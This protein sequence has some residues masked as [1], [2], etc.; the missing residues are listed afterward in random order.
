MEDYI[1]FKDYL[2]FGRDKEIKP[3][4]HEEQLLF[5]DKV[6][7]I[8]RLGFSKERNIILTNQAF[9]NLDGKSKFK[10]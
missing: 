2:C 5:S 3:I 1:E 4:I 9:Y 8:V 7:K 6:Y 10:K